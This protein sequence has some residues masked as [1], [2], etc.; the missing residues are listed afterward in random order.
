[1]HLKVIEIKY[2]Y[3]KIDGKRSEEVT[4]EE[5]LPLHEGYLDFNG[6]R[7]NYPYN[8]LI[9]VKEIK[10]NE[11]VLIML[12]KNERLRELIRLKL[13]TEEVFYHKGPRGIPYGYLY[14]LILE[15]DNYEK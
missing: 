7:E 1:M 11:I 12:N 6:V 4:K 10:E 15:D 9:Y 14:H 13:N 2:R 8:E 3:S 5:T